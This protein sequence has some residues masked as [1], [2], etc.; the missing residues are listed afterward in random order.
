MMIPEQ[1]SAILK[2]IPSNLSILKNQLLLSVL[3]G[4]FVL[5]AVP[6]GNSLSAPPAESADWP[7]IPYWTQSGDT[8][9]AV[10]QRFRVEADD[11]SS[12]VPIKMDG[13][14]E[15][16]QLLLI[17]Q[18]EIETEGEYLNLDSKKLFPDGEVVFGPTAAYFDVAEY[19]REAGGYLGTYREY[20]GTSKWTEASAVI[21]RIA[22]ENSI[23]PRL[24]IALLEYECGCVLGDSPG[25][26]GEGYV[27]GV[28]EF[29]HRWLYRQLGWVANQL[30][31]GYYGWRSGELIEY[32]LPDGIILRPNPGSNAGSAAIVYF[33]SQLSA[34]KKMQTI[35]VGQREKLGAIEI[36]NDWK[37]AVNREDG[38]STL[39]Q[40]MF[41]DPWMISKKH[42]PLFPLGIEQPEMQLPFELG[43]VWSYT[44]GPHKA[45]QTEGALAALDFAPATY[46]TGCIPTDAFV[47]AVADGTAVRVGN[48]FVIQ[49][50]DEI[51]VQGNKQPGDL[52]EQTGWAVLYMHIASTDKVRQG[53]YLD[54]GDPIGHPSCEGGPATGTHLHIARKYNGEWIAADGPLSFNLSGWTA[55]IG[56]APYLGTLNRDGETVIAHNY[57]NY[58]TLISLRE[59]DLLS[60]IEIQEKHKS[61]LEY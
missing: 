3:I 57:G 27:M 19:L 11:I 33:F 29:Q 15:A 5:S 48:G 21:E 23:N 59:D 52:K 58:E 49:D 50:L 56:D 47:A 34:Q 40:S 13:L 53:Q 9:Q 60:D 44:S 38:F 31:I 45:W 61:Q 41:G 16:G 51:D 2:L 22:L 54:K 36:G 24:L 42:G 46:E 32:Q 8:L 7:Y 18:P 12:P 39:Y 25:R 10:A 35:P 14:L 55:H 28:E 37:A 30:S 20:L 17:P 4:V 6:N 43:V 1:I 26:L